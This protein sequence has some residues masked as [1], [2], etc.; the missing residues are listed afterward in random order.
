MRGTRSLNPRT[1]LSG[2]LITKKG[3]LVALL[4]TAALV[5][6]LAFGRSALIGIGVA[7]AAYL[8]VGYLYAPRASLTG[9]LALSQD[10]LREDDQ[11]A[12]T[13]TVAAGSERTGL[14]EMHVALPGVTRVMEGVPMDLAALSRGADHTVAFE[15]QVPAR[16]VYAI[17]PLEVRARDP[18]GLFANERVLA[19][20]R[21]LTIY[22]RWRTIKDLPIRAKNPR[23]LAG[24]Y[25]V[26]Q[27]GDGVE[28]FG[29]RDYLP[30]DPMRSVNWKASAKSSEL[31]V[32]QWER[33][34]VTEATLLVDTR[35]ITG[36]GDQLENPLLHTTRLAATLTS[37]FMGGRDSV[38]VVLY[39]N[40]VRSH[41]GGRGEGHFHA[42]LQDLADVTPDGGITLGHAVDLTL[43]H[44]IP[45][46]PVIV[47]TVA[48][49][50]PSLG[51]ALARLR[52][53]G[54]PVLVL[55]P[56]L[57]FPDT[58]AGAL[59]REAYEA[60]LSAARGVGAVVHE[61]T[62]QDD[63]IVRIGEEIVA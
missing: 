22:P 28:F 14:V 5:A 35:R 54:N 62:D 11:F 24:R 13:A 4:A 34:S 1:R 44:L 50:D 16:G 60:G 20:A 38:R 17:G 3:V 21:S 19:D 43:P 25:T 48:A 36:L 32:N 7:L 61:F 46:S 37:Y 58:P 55:V 47:I 53:Q 52:A 9:T 57:A 10:T 63:A 33:E 41:R 42:I 12:V 8:A 6:G 27:P 59:L 18:F 23:M 40:G 49:G 29:L 2:P 56:R 45:R 31:V 39:G 26:H 51:D 15:A 30:G